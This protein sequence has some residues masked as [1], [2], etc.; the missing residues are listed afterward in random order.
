MK[1]KN[2]CKSAILTSIL[3]ISSE[4]HNVQQTIQASFLFI[5]FF[6]VRC[7]KIRDRFL[8][9]T[10]LLNQ[11]YIVSPSAVNLYGFFGQLKKVLKLN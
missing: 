3:F 6:F 10:L 2:L 11:I 7:C 1:K 4:Q 8:I 5:N 9:I